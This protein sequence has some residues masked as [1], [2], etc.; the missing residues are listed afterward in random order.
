MQENHAGRSPALMDS[1]CPRSPVDAGTGAK[2]TIHSDTLLGNP[3]ELIE[4]ALQRAKT[5]GDAML[6]I[7][8]RINAVEARIDSVEVNVR[9]QYAVLEDVQRST[10]DICKKCSAVV[11]KITDFCTESFVE[12]LLAQRLDQLKADLIDVLSTMNNETRQKCQMLKQSDMLHV[13]HQEPSHRDIAPE[14]TIAVSQLIDMMKK[15]EDSNA[16]L[17]SCTMQQQE[18]MVSVGK[19][20]EDDIKDM[21]KQL[22]SGNGSPSTAYSQPDGVATSAGTC[23]PCAEVDDASIE[24]LIEA[25]QNQGPPIRPKMGARSTIPS[26]VGTSRHQLL[27]QHLPQM[28]SV[29]LAAGMSMHPERGRSLSSHAPVGCDISEAGGH[30]EEAYGKVSRPEKWIHAHRSASQ[31]SASSDYADSNYQG[32]P[33]PAASVQSV[34]GV[35]GLSLSSSVRSLRQP[36]SP[37]RLQL[38]ASQSQS[39]LQQTVLKSTEVSTRPTMSQAM[40]I[41]RFPAAVLTSPEQSSRLRMPLHRPIGTSSGH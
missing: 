28:A 18:L 10:T 38:H 24:G 25:F 6:D 5:Q 3:W 22:V 40:H 31:C 15:L 11:E 9:A 16:Y 35:K 17:T 8:K 27:R 12:K 32:K 23:S 1:S 21:R 2:P 37:Q 36:P 34:T 33:S 41:Q 14:G 19:K 26:Y 4:V 39:N 7:G 29:V 20:V 30:K 13:G